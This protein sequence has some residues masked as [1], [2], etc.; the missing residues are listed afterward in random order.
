MD[1]LLVDGYN[2]IG[3]WE[4]LQRLR[5]GDMA[6]AR[7]LLIE[8]MA[9]YQAFTGMKVIIV[10]DAHE[11][12]GKESKLKQFK[13]EVIYTKENETADERIERL[14]KKLKNVKTQVYVATNDYTEQRTIFA[15][16]AL[17]ISARE[18]KVDIR[19][20]EEEIDERL[21]E[22]EKKQ[23]QTKIILDQDILERFEKMR[24]GEN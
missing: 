18:L 7:D 13:I 24:R 14:I 4:E 1:I 19:D 15:Q 10:F 17:R 22:Q 20:M 8:R 11:A 2:I 12:P 9:E 5:D 3:D 23:P 16:G 21:K 6:A